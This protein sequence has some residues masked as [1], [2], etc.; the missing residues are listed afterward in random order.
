MLFL[1]LACNSN[2]GDETGQPNDDTGSHETGETGETGTETGETGKETGETG[3]DDTGGSPAPKLT[4]SLDPSVTTMVHAVWTESKDDASLEYRFE[5]KTWLPAPAIEPGEGVILGIPAQTDV[6]VRVVET[7]GDSVVYSDVET[8]ET[9]TLPP[10]MTLP[11]VPFY[12]PTIAYDAQY[13]MISFAQGAGG[14]GPPWWIQ[15]LDREGRVVWWHRVE[16]SLM[17]FYP[18]VALDG[19][20]IWFDAEDIFGTGTGHPFVQR[21]TLDGRWKVKLEVDAMGEA[22]A[23]GPDDSWY[24]E[25]RTGWGASDTVA[26]AHLAPDGTRDMIWDCSAVYGS[27]TCFMNTC[28]WSEEHGTVLA[29][30]FFSD[31]VFEVDVATGEVI[32]QMGQLTSGD[33]YAFDPTDSM[34]AYQHNPYWLDT[35]NL[36]VS[37]HI[38]GVDGTQVAAEYSVDDSTQTLTRVWS[39]VSTDIWAQQM[40]EAIRLPNGNTMQGYGQNGAAREVTPDGEIAWEVYWVTPPAQ[41]SVGHL[42]LIED[43]YALNVGGTTKK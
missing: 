37:T 12:D 17:S 4:L 25:Y 24:Y 34:F 41:R 3:N 1:L 33:P 39:Y 15:I 8:I 19:T 36:L 23:E 13:A 16:D 21:Q 28:N 27:E 14:Y 35:G 31:T 6:E 38:V 22:I 20:H 29:S 26:L 32:R 10:N 30:M 7:V 40:G 9:G 42:T 11:D 18:S 2:Q 5:G 43:L